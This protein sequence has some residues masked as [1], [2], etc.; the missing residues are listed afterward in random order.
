MA[1]PCR[2]A[3]GD[4]RHTCSRNDGSPVP[5]GSV[6]FYEAGAQ[7]S[8]RLSVEGTIDLATDRQALSA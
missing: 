2:F 6:C 3:A 4:P 5:A 1:E 8:E 7:L